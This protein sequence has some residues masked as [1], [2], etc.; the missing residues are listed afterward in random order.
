MGKRKKTVKKRDLWYAVAA[1]AA[2]GVLAVIAIWQGGGE[3]KVPPVEDLTEKPF[4]A[5]ALGQ[6]LEVTQIADYAGVYM[7]DGSDEVL[8]R[9]MMLI[10][11]N[12]S[13]SDLQLARVYVEY[14]GKTCAFEATNLPAGQSV[15]LLEKNR[16]RCPAQ[17][18]H[19]IRADSVVFFDAPMT[20]ADGRLTVSGEE[21]VI[22]V[23]N[24]SDDDLPG[25]IY[26]YYKNS[27]ADLLYGGITY[28]ATLSGGLAKG[29]TG[30]IMTGHYDP[31]TCRIVHIICEG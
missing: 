21:G 17:N 18:Y 20:P 2:C 15:V 7:E 6:G 19:S 29:E 10:L 9:V 24:S 1:I 27:S 5:V 14:E 12:G 13:A 23:T 30:S 11:H 8:S 22:R 4:E 26:V 16:E 3:G 28:R 25:K 31:D